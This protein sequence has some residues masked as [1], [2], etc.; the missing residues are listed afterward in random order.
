MGRDYCKYGVSGA[1]WAATAL[2]GYVWAPK[3]GHRHM[4]PLVPLGRQQAATVR[5]GVAPLGLLSSLVRRAI[6][7]SLRVL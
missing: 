2:P 4:V 7:V 5:L 3:G 1:L 6:L